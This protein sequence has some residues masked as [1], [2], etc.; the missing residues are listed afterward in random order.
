M[1]SGVRRFVGKVEGRAR[2]LNDSAIAPDSG[3]ES[4]CIEVDCNVSS[5]RENI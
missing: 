1:S 5:V 2:I 4:E 3:P